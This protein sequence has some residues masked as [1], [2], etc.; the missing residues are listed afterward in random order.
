[1]PP[2]W[3]LQVQLNKLQELRYKWAL[4]HKLALLRKL[5]LLNS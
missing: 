5:A 1:M 3:L 4:Q 2:Q